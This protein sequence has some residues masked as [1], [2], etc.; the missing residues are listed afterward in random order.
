M[1]PYKSENFW[2]EQIDL[3]YCLPQL[4]LSS[5]T[6]ER[7]KVGAITRENILRPTELGTIGSVD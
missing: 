7:E 2:L 6:L 4:S 3:I 1:V 5:D